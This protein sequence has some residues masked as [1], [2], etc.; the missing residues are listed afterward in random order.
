MD[1]QL[2]QYRALEQE[3]K[4]EHPDS[5]SSDGLE[6]YEYL[7]R[8]QARKPSI[9][10]RTL[11]AVTFFTSLLLNAVLLWRLNSK[12]RCHDKPSPL[13]LYAN[14]EYNVAKPFEWH[15]EYNGEN[16]TLADELWDALGTQIDT[17]FIAVPDEWSAEK[18]LLEAQRFPWDTSKGIY[19]VNGQHNLHC[20]RNVRKAYMEYHTGQ[21]QSMT[22][23]HVNH[24]FDALRQD[25]MCHADDTP[26]YTT[27]TNDPESGVGQMRQCRS[28]DKLQE[29]TRERTAC[30][31]NIHEGQRIHEIERYKFCPPGSP[32]LPKIR[33]YF[34]HNDDWQPTLDPIIDHKR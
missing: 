34:K 30:F 32:Y 21:N 33:G 15:T 4:A 18:G 12:D 20:L 10:W 5:S 31:R 3:S 14:L 26:R 19:L 2:S 29:W 24:C 16:Q 27:T 17:G 8:K 9:F 1:H 6:G 11:T 22:F 28:W 13:S 23:P 7:P 25:I